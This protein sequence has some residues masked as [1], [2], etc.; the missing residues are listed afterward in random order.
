MWNNF[1]K[2]KKNINFQKV[3]KNFR[4]NKN[5]TFSKIEKIFNFWEKKMRNSF[6]NINF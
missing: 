4:N 6:N 5:K 1:W 3:S 2:Y